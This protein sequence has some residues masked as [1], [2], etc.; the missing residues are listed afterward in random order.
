MLL[1]ALTDLKERH[2]AVTAILTANHVNVFDPAVIRPGRVDRVLAFEPPSPKDREVILKG[3][4]KEFDVKV[5]DLK[6]FVRATDGLTAAYLRE[7][8]I[9][10][11]NTRDAKEVLDTI[12]LMKDLAENKSAAAPAVSTTA[13]APK[14]S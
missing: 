7:V 3:Y 12:K 8:A 11:K 1:E 14:A 13:S 2:P 5:P 6:A 4:L 9:Q 10:L